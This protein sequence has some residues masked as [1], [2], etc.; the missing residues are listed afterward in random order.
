[1]VSHTAKLDRSHQGIL[2]MY[3]HKCVTQRIAE[4]HVVPG[5]Y[6]P[7]FIHNGDYHLASI[8]AYK[9]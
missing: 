5:V 8:V 1:M 6:F 3:Y 9:A 4:G 7:A 2:L